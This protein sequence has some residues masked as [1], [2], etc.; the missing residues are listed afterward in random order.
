[1]KRRMLR[2]FSSFLCIVSIGLAWAAFAPIPQDETIPPERWQTGTKAVLPFYAGLYND[3]PRTNAPPDNPSTPEKAS[4]GRLLFF[5]PVLSR[6]NDMSCST[7]HHPDLGFSD[8]RQ[9]GMGA[10]GTGYGVQRTGGVVFPRNTLTQ[11]NVAYNKSLLWN[12]S[13]STLEQ[14]IAG[15]MVSPE[16]FASNPDQVVDELRTIPEYVHLFDAAFGSDAEAVSFVNIA[17]AIATFQRSLISNNSPYDRYAAGDFDALTPQQRRGL[18]LFRSSRTRCNDCH[19]APTFSDD[20][21]S[22]TGVPPLPGT[23]YD[24]GRAAVDPQGMY[25]AFKAPTLRNIAL[26]APYMHNGVFPSLEKVMDFYAQGGGRKDGVENMDVHVQGFTLTDSERAELVAFLYALTDEGNLA[27]IPASVPSGLPV[28]PRLE[29]PGRE[30]VQRVNRSESAEQDSGGR[31]PR[32]FTVESGQTIQSVI[33]LAQAGDTVQ[34]PFGSYSESVVV[35]EPGIRLVGLP[36]SRGDHPILDGDGRLAHGVLASADGFEMAFLDLKRYSDAQVLVKNASNLFLHDISIAGPGLLGL[37]LQSCSNVRVEDVHVT[38]MKSAGVY[39]SSSEQVSLLGVDS[40]NNAIGME[41]ENS[42][43]STIQSSHAHGNA[44][45]IFV[46]LQ[47]HLQSKVSLNTLL[48]DNVVENNNAEFLGG[49]A[50]PDGTGILVLAADDVESRGNTIRGHRRAGL[51][52]VSRTGKLAQTVMDVGIYP[53]HFAADRNFYAANHADVIWDGGGDG[54]NFDDETASSVPGVLPSSE[55][56]KPFYRLYW[57]AL[58][59]FGRPPL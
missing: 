18:A 5:D 11:W 36:N 20:G 10:G 22:V 43:Y 30:A 57:W 51:V 56:I 7:C 45:G 37:S 41:L 54:S 6:D 44:L 42:V 8:G 38:A 12:G 49:Q 24:P 21:F 28:V 26:T 46:L 32:V 3:F 9:T 39:V 29:N 25:R 31:H 2:L 35:D 50:L 58:R 33:D 1:M 13:L 40:Y 27:E 48:S 55:W 15:T 4:L 16:E 23:E 53:D 34:I 19:S 59:L 17:R 47:P 52:V 14:V